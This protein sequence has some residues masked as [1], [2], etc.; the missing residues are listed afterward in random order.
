MNQS[1]HQLL[2]N[3]NKYKNL[4]NRENQISYGSTSLKKLLE[5]LDPKDQED[6]GSYLFFQKWSSLRPV[7]SIISFRW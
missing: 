4:N 3:V 5:T 6:G 1:T 7:G 2:L